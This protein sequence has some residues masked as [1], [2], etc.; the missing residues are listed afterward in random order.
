V[1]LQVPLLAP[2]ECAAL[3]DALERRG[4]EPMATLYPPDYR[5][6]D[7][8]ILDDAALAERLARRLDGV[9]P[10]VIERDSARWHLTGLNERFRSCRYE[11]GQSFRLHRDGPHFRSAA[12][13]SW[14]T[15]MAYLNDGFD[16]GRTRFYDGRDGRMETAVEPRAGR[17]VVFDHAL[18]HDGEAVT[19]GRKY[20]LRTD[21]LYR[22]EGPAAPGGALRHP[23]YVWCVAPLPDRRLATACRDGRVRVWRGGEV[24]AEWRG[25]EGSVTALAWAG[26]SLATGS[27]G[28]RVRLWD[29]PRLAFDSGATGDAI[30]ALAAA[31][32]GA[33]LASTA[34]GEVLRIAGGRLSRDR[35]GRGWQWG[36]AEVAPG[37]VVTAA[38]P[39]RAIAAGPGGRYATGDAEGRIRVWSAEGEALGGFDAHR[40]TVRSIAWFADGRLASGGEDDAARVWRDGRLLAE[41][42]HSDFVTAVAVTAEG[43]LA[44]ASYDGTVRVAAG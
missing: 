17:A 12:E 37:R 23:G 18:W 14:L 8:L 20:V 7:R 16:G 27:R 43:L 15:V 33:V 6:N 42:R 30:L 44:S 26:G 4:F 11:G 40:G 5:D 28:G 2:D 9:L 13:R 1:I 31:S 36:I 22:R 39:L 25:D 32:D 24:E 35:A 34:G 21:V 19:R 29:G 41:R 3:I 38:E 10:R